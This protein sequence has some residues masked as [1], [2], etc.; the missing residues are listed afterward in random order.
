MEIFL[1]RFYFLC[2]MISYE[3]ED[4]LDPNEQLVGV[5]SALVGAYYE[6]RVDLAGTVLSVGS[7][8]GRRWKNELWLV[9]KADYEKLLQIG[10]DSRF[11]GKLEIEASELTEE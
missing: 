7:S 5:Y 10:F 1:K 6:K 2:F 4:Y 11:L 3:F 9:R 8:I